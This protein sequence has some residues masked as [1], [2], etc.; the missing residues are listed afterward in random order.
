MPKC[1]SDLPT[2]ENEIRLVTDVVVRRGDILM[3]AYISSHALEI[4][5]PLCTLNTTQCEVSIT[6]IKKKHKRREKSMTCRQQSHSARLSAVMQDG[7]KWSLSS[8]WCTVA[9]KPV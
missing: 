6:H 2:I 7:R 4:S 8:M 5:V 9:L 1:D 3:F